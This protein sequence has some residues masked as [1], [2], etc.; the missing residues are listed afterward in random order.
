MGG[1]LAAQFRDLKFWHWI[2]N[3][4]NQAMFSLHTATV[5]GKKIGKDNRCL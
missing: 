3:H 5:T 4:G 2:D 1:E